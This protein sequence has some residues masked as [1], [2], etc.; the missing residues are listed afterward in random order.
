MPIWELISGLNKSQKSNFTIKA[1]SVKKWLLNHLVKKLTE[2]VLIN[3]AN[4]I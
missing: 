2:I 1:T 3:S 4:Q